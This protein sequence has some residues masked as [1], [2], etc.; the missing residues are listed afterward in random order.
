[1]LRMM[2]MS[3]TIMKMTMLMSMTLIL[4][5]WT[6]SHILALDGDNDGEEDG[7][8]DDD[9]D[10][11]DGDDDDAGDHSAVLVPIS[12]YWTPPR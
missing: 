11:E 8:L 6:S 2:R 4:V 1:M 10:E 9:D 3:T 7:V 5:Y 12:V